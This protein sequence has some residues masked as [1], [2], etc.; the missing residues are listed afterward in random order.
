MIILSGLK[1]ESKITEKTLDKES[2]DSAE[3][4]EIKE[5]LNKLEEK[6]DYLVETKEEENNS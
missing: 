3:I 4:K 6:I 2:K 5:T 1:K